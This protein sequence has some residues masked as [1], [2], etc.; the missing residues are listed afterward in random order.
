MTFFLKINFF[1][2]YFLTQN[3]F[4]TQNIQNHGLER[5]EEESI[6]PLGSATDCK[7]LWS[8]ASSNTIKLQFQHVMVAVP[9]EP[10]ML[11]FENSSESLIT[12]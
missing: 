4:L 10:I 12:S 7:D 9:S 8:K 6:R 5:L 3:S 2:V 11:D 1:K